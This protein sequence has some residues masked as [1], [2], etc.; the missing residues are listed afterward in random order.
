MGGVMWS[1]SLMSGLGY[2]FNH[3]FVYN[4]VLLVVIA[5]YFESFFMVEEARCDEGRDDETVVDD[6]VTRS[7]T[8]STVPSLAN[9]HRISRP[10]SLCLTGEF[11]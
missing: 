2:P 11:A 7:L 6:P 1:W 3:H 5:N 4:A 8:A 10:S 9:G